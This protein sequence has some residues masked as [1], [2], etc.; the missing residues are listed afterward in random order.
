MTKFI[1]PSVHSP[2]SRDI[3]R[4]RANGRPTA[5]TG[6]NSHRI[7][8]SVGTIEALAALAQESRLAIIRLLFRAGADGLSAGVIARRLALPAPTLSFHL[9]RLHHGGLLVSRR[10]GNSIVYAAS[11]TGMNALLTYLTENCCQGF[12]EIDA[13][14]AGKPAVDIATFEPGDDSDEAPPRVPRR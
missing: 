13:G 14:A 11:Y 8:A 10:E 9:S 5:V 2:P 6:H 4:R 1:A 12:P 3:K 7:T